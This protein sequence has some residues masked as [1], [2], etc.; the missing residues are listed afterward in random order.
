MGPRIEPCGTPPECTKG[1]YKEELMFTD[2]DLLDTNELNQLI[3]WPLIP[4]SRRRN[5]RI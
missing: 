2:K 4:I 5:E 3:T 1:T